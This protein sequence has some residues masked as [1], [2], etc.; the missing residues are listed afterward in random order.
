MV[1]E[2]SRREALQHYRAGQ[3]ALSAESWDEAEREFQTAI[4][5][6][7]NLTAAHY[8]LG[9]VYMA[10]KRYPPAVRAYIRCRE[11]FKAEAAMATMDSAGAERRLEE[12]I[13]TLKDELLELQS[14]QVRA[15]SNAAIAVRL[16][17][18]LD[19][20]EGRRHRGDGGPEPV[21]ASISIALGSAYF[22]NGDLADAEREYRAALVVKPDLGEAH[23]NL[24]VVHML[25]G[26]L[27][28]AEQELKLA[29]KAGFRVNPGL[30]KDLQMRKEQP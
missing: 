10:T 28:K 2:K 3:S 25:T 30:K 12:Q 24:A 22:R 14:R 15:Q 18:Q 29:E 16:Q 6:D 1:D 7:P 11:A 8:G 19:E 13:Q 5:L 20:L 4:S 27:D 21:P 26:R 17:S 9:Q 23:N